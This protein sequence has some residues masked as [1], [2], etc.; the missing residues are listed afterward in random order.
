VTIQKVNTSRSVANRS[1][2][3]G[4]KG[5]LFYD[6]ADGILYISDGRTPGGTL[7]SGGGGSYTLPTASSSV[8]GGVKIGSNITITA[9]VISVAAPFSGS[10][11][12]LTNQPTI[13]TNT[14]QL[15]NGAG[16]ITST[17]SLING[18]YSA[19][20][21]SSG[22]F[23]VPGNFTVSG[24]QTYIQGTNTV[25][26]DN[27]IELH[28][29]TGGVGG[30]WS[31]SDGKDIGLRLHYYSSGD[32]NAA[33]VLAQDTGYLEWYSDGTETNGVFS[34]TYGDIKA[35][36]FR[37]TGLTVQGGTGTYYAARFQGS[38][39]GDQFAIGLSST[40][41]YGAGNDVLNSGGTAYAP[42]TISASQMTFKVGS[43]VPATALSFDTSGNVN[44][45][46][47]GTGSVN[48]TG[49]LT[50]NGGGAV[51]TINKLQT[52]SFGGF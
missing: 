15:T 16:F 37:G 46:A 33:L 14:N 8:L 9:G 48:I 44:I 40:A 29:P 18:L 22:N 1:T 42:Y 17:N 41:G 32:K 2:Y 34:G 3:V 51:S 12:D 11:T 4:E 52:Q 39:G 36:T 49:N 30:T 10:Y 26:T 47:K 50:L 31:S 43:S 20:L 21:D 45:I 24:N 25:Y 7:I 38:T 27:L 5:R 19:T 35:A 6:E 23:T 28:A 13:P